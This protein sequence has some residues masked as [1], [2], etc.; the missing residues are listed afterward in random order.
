MAAAEGRKATNGIADDIFVSLPAVGGL[1][2]GMGS[3][4]GVIGSTKGSFSNGAGMTTSMS[5][6]VC[7]MHKQHVS[8]SVERIR[9]ALP[10]H[11]INLHWD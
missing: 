7:K 6:S 8:H 3:D 5:P 9:Y 11:P 2:T 10:W 1:L 4:L